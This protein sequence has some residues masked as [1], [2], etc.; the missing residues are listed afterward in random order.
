MRKFLL[1]A[2]TILLFLPAQAG[3]ISEIDIQDQESAQ[4]LCAHEFYNQCINKCDKT[5]YG[6]CTQACE[7]NAKNQCLQAGE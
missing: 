2:V 5:N 1:S 7:E 4:E 6:D 3:D